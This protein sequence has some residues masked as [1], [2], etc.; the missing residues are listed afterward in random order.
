MREPSLPS[1]KSRRENLN[2][3]ISMIKSEKL[4]K[5]NG[6][7]IPIIYDVPHNANKIVIMIH[8]FESLKECATGQMLFRRMV[9]EGIGVIAYDQPGH[10]TEE[11]AD[12]KLTL[13]N[14]MDSLGCVEDF[15][16][17]LFP[18]AQISYFGSSFGAYVTGLYISS[19]KH[20]GKKFFMRSAAVNMPE[21]F[22][23][24][25]DP[26]AEKLLREQ[27][28]VEPDMGT[29]HIV[30][31]PLQLFED[32]DEND[33]FEKFKQGEVSAMMVHGEQDPVIDPKKAKA[34]ASKFSIPITIMPGEGHSICTNS[35]SPDKVGD[36]AIAFFRN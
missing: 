8:G 32:L 29:G 34:F 36:L 18:K 20:R 21:L 13:D 12:E 5:K 7:V 24:N 28:Y 30:K 23:G 27:G 19:R 11:A 15:A 16:A 14:C 3:K 6:A 9:P 1:G 26:E 25:P 10:G 31:V 33:L 35:E 22:L 17:E 2:R 4:H